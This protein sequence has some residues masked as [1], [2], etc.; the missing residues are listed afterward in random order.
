MAQQKNSGCVTCG[1]GKFRK[2]HTRWCW[3]ND[4]TQPV[5]GDDLVVDG[6]G[7]IHKVVQRLAR[8]SA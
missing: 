2:T 1:A 8:V 3:T 5:A 7:W 6:N 4:P